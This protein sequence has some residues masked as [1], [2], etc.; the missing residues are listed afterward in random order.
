MAAV[1]PTTSNK[2]VGKDKDGDPN[3]KLYCFKGDSKYTCA[4]WKKFNANC[5]NSNKNCNTTSQAWVAAITVCKQK[6]F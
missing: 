4:T 2:C 1:T 5:I 6:L 3:L